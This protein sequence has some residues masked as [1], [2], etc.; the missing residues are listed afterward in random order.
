[1]ISAKDL[2]EIVSSQKASIL[3]LEKNV[4][5]LKKFKNEFNSYSLKPE[6]TF[7]LDPKILS[8]YFS[9]SYENMR[10]L[11]KKHFASDD[12]FS[13]WSLYCRSYYCDKYLK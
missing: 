5:E 4:N 10:Q 7:D 6:M 12:N 1:M 8:D 3:A 11:K 9:K 13:Q 2:Y